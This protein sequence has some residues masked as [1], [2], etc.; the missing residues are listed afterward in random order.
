MNKFIHAI[1]Q[2]SLIPILTFFFALQLQAQIN[3]YQYTIE[4]RAVGKQ[5]AVSSAHP[6]ASAVGIEILK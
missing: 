3:P 5:G 4:K 2:F 6:L 1:G